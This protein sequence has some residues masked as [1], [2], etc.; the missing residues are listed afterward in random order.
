MCVCV[1]EGER[2]VELSEL[3]SNSD[4][5]GNCRIVVGAQGATYAG[6]RP[7]NP[8]FTPETHSAVF[9][10]ATRWRGTHTRTTSTQT[11][12]EAHA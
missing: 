9:P 7:L 1:F 11:N 3:V 12:A 10:E 4:L 2:H 8:P 6:A 5:W